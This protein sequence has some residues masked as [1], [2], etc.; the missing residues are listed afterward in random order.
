LLAEMWIRAVRRSQ[1][2]FV[3]ALAEPDAMRAAIAGALSERHA[4]I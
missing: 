1:A 2:A 3:D 4:A